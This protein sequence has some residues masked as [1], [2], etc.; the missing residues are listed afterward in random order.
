M[1]LSTPM[2]AA[3]HLQTAAHVVSAHILKVRPEGTEIACILASGEQ[4]TFSR[5]IG[6]QIRPGDEI[7]FVA[8][9][10]PVA[11]ATEVYVSRATGRRRAGIYQTRIGYA[12]QPKTDKRNDLYVRAEVSQGNLGISA[13]HLPCRAL[14]D[15][16]YT[17]NRQRPWQSQTSLYQLLRIPATASATELRVAYKL[18]ALE[19]QAEGAPMAG[20]RTLERAFNLL[21]Q[22]ELRACYN[23]L[24]ID[25]EAPVLFPYGGF[26]SILV[27]GDRSPDGQTFFVTRILSFLPECRE[28]RFRAPLRRIDYYND[29]AIYRDPRRKLEIRLDR[30]TLPIMSD[31]TWNRWK[32]LLRAKVDVKATFIETGVYQHRHGEWRLQRYEIAL[33]SRVEVK[34][35]TD[36][37]DQVDAARKTYHRF[38]QFSAVLE[39]IRARFEKEPVERE[40]LRRLCWDLRIPGDFDVVQINWRPDYDPFFFRHLNRQARRLYLFREEYIFELPRAIAVETPQLGHATYLFARSP[41]METF[42]SV[43]ARSTK[44]DIRQNRQN[45]AEMLGFLGR[46]MHG[47]N[48]RTWAKELDDRA[49]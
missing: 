27:A 14:R 1:L 23:R 24:L 35:P 6:D 20:F 19:L 42:L 34:V 41:D 7:T 17:A 33:P 22:P 47:V 3:V 32:H 12:A 28:R 16:F 29:H 26:G 21:A 18:R 40:E 8:G 31:T 30:S 15:Y 5:L 43:Y 4:L 49:G 36:I 38:G 48:P 9:A 44:E 2:E 25:P 13:I 11:V 39:R 10:D 37:A 46:V 45:T